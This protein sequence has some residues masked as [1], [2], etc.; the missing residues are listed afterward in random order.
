MRS[1]VKLNTDGAAKR[2]DEI[3]CG[4]VLRGANGVWICG[5]S[6][7]LG[8]CCVYVMELQGFL[9]G[10]KLVLVVIIIL[11]FLIDCFKYH[12]KEGRKPAGWSF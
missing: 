5:F 2:R 7:R 11:N 9:E 6:K 1:W 4:G 8:V 10:L 3:G 12:S